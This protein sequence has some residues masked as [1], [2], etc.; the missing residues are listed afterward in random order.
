[1]RGLSYEE[2]QQGGGRV[3]FARALW[4]LCR[5]L[6]LLASVAGCATSSGR[7]RSGGDGGGCDAA[8]TKRTGGE[9]ACYEDRCA[10][11]AMHPE[12]V[13]SFRMTL[14][15]S[16]DAERNIPESE[17]IQNQKCV[18][19]LL[20]RS[21]VRVLPD[22]TN[23]N[24]HDVIAVGSTLDEVRPALELKIVE[25]VEPGCVGGCPHCA[26]LS[27]G[28][29]C[30]E[31]PFCNSINARKVT[32]RNG[33]AE[34]GDIVPVL[35]F[36]DDESCEERPALAVDDRGQCWF[37]SSDCSTITERGWR[38][39]ACAPATTCEPQPDRI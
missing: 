7:D 2:S 39:S 27:P 26:G 15:K 10:Y 6:L 4:V 36:H 34:L 29:S 35:C 18:T 14:S 22:S 37:F 9:A 17:Q 5:C 12:V 30:D 28:E 13:V 25:N 1:M 3:C 16:L 31:D 23:D 21:G 19:D 32:E 38:F 8:L 24:F 11:L 33:C 20:T